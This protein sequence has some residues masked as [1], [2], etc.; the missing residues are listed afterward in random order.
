LKIV[1]RSGIAN[2]N[3][4]KLATDDIVA[5]PSEEE[6]KDFTKEAFHM[7]ST[8]KYFKHTKS[9]TISLYF[10]LTFVT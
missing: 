2:G 9:I 10:S 6:N 5:K 1:V 8:P 4:S 3:G 7:F